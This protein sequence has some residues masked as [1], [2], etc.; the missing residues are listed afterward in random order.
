MRCVLGALF[1]FVFDRLGKSMV[2]PFNLWSNTMEESDN[3]LKLLQSASRFVE[4][5]CYIVNFTSFL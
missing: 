4:V 5:F 2:S 1:P 3:M